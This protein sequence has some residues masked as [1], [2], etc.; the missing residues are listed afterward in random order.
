MDPTLA[1]P[2]LAGKVDVSNPWKHVLRKHGDLVK[3]DRAAAAAAASARRSGASGASTARQRTLSGFAVPSAPAPEAP[4]SRVVQAFSLPQR[5]RLLSA[6]L[7]LISYSAM[8]TQGV[9]MRIAL[10]AIGGLIPKPGGEAFDIAFTPPARETVVNFEKQWVLD[11]DFEVQKEWKKEGILGSDGMPKASAAP[12]VSIGFDGSSTKINGYSSISLNT[13]WLQQATAT[14]RRFNVGVTKFA[15]RSDGAEATE[16]NVRGTG[17]NLAMWVVARLKGIGLVPADHIGL[18]V[19]RYI[20]AACTDNASAEIKA[21]LGFLK[22]FHH[23]CVCHSLELVL[24]HS[25][26]P[27]VSAHALKTY[28]EACAVAAAAGDPLPNHPRSRFGIALDLLAKLAKFQ[29]VSSRSREWFTYAEQKGVANPQPLIS[30][31]ATRWSM[32]FDMF[33]RAVEYRAYIPFLFNAAG[34]TIFTPNTWTCIV[35]CI[36]FLWL[37]KDAIINCQSR[38]QLIGA[39]MVHIISI[40]DAINQPAHVRVLRHDFEPTADMLNYHAPSGHTNRL[41]RWLKDPAYSILATAGVLHKSVNE[42]LIQLKHQ[43]TSRL[44]DSGGSHQLNSVCAMQAMIFDPLLKFYICGAVDAAGAV[45]DVQFDMCPTGYKMTEVV[46]PFVNTG[47]ALELE[48]R[49]VTVA[50][51]GADNATDSPPPSKS[52]RGAVG[53]KLMEQ[54]RRLTGAAPIAPS[55]TSDL[56]DS[57]S[58]FMDEWRRWRARP[59]DAEMSM[60]EFWTSTAAKEAFPIMRRLFFSVCSTRPDNA[61]SERDFSRLTRLLSPL[62]R[63]KMSVTTVERKARG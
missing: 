25:V 46:V 41:Q 52:R 26:D 14:P 7:L 28:A 19:S 4:P 42:M 33:I 62:R 30:R 49:G 16:T 1:M 48:L 60:R 8:M 51:G 29:K 47:K 50:S 54:V 34:F 32:A 15:V 61:E 20:R 45:S 44:G 2:R 43:M 56:S 27:A 63:G 55:R 57:D 10:G 3:A 40:W 37:F 12:L 13:H 5:Q 9:F 24:K 36:A 59:A 18:D 23:P 11:C 38:E 58:V 6:A 17:E 53:Q 35:Q 31:S 22:I 21:V 39:H